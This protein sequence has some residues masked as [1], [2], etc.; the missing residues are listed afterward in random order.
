MTDSNKRPA[1][2]DDGPG[3]GA[4]VEAK[5]PRTDGELVVAQQSKRPE[6]KQQGPARTS[7]LQAPIMLLSGHGDAVF[8]M[9]FNPEGDVIA[10]GS[11]DKHIFLWRTYGECENYMML[12]GHKNAVLEV[13]WTP[14]GERLISCSPDKTVRC[15]DAVTGEQVKKMG[16]HKDIV[17]SCCPLRRGPPLLV[18]GGDDCEAKLWDLR[19]KRAVKSFSE[20]YQIL[21]VAFSDGGDQIYTA[22]IENVVNVWDLR[23]EEVSM[24]LAGHNDSITGMRLSPDG[25]HLLTNSMDN[26]LR[27]WDMRPYAPANRCTK[28]FAGHVHTFEKNLLRCDWSP[29]GQKVTAGSGDR[30]VYIWSAASRALMY[31]LPGHGGSVNE[32]VFHPREP[33]VGSASSDKTIYL[34]ELAQ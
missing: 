28:V 20:R 17:N 4:L 11:H 9:R 24:S 34:G 6:V 2:E 5:K 23:R 21:T 7:A 31:K 26:T 19:Q 33:I 27:V 29:D 32:C 18:S 14:D 30:C 22:G 12:K 13:H 16:E 8:T 25:S 3:A 15:W 1:Q 10:S